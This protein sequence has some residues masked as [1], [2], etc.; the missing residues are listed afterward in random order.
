MKKSLIAP[1]AFGAFALVLGGCATPPAATS[2]S[3]TASA[4]ATVAQSD[5]KAC[6]VS[7]SGGFDDKSFNETAYAGLTKA[8]AELGVQK[9]EVQS[10]AAAD[11]AKNVQEMVNQKCDIIVTVG[12]AL[13][14]ATL[15]AAKKNP[16]IDFA[17]VDHSYSDDEGK[18]TAP[19]NLKGLVF[20]ASEP[21]FLAGYLAASLSQTGKVGT[22]GGAPYPA[23]TSFMDGYARGVAYY[24]QQKGKSVAVLGW[25]TT[26]KD[27]TFIG[28]QSPFDDVPGGKKVATN[29]MAQG[30][31]I[32]LPVAGPSSEGAL[33]VAKASNGKVG[34]LWVDTDGCISQEQYCSIIP[35]SVA[36]AMDVAVF[37]A[38]KAAK[39]D[40]FSN[41][42]Y[43]GTL[44]NGGTFLAPF[45]DW[46]SKVT[47]ETKAELD[48]I[49]AGIIDGSIKTTA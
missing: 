25:D 48:A 10:A 28:G 45:H 11:Y 3:A 7:D 37:E 6:M 9:N 29:L 26:K 22:F 5:F 44:A 2:A 18:N 20:D 30:A 12:F 1:V 41:E 4:S 17:I 13:G 19:D 36:K 33:Q 38:I 42:P 24:N 16:D 39:D 49:K 21:S 8:V 35:S 40:K 27:G 47:D 15:A 14:D 23:V 32:L 46:D 43:L 34:S 31:D